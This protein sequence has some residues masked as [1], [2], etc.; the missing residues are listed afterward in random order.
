M[1]LVIKKKQNLK[2]DVVIKYRVVCQRLCTVMLGFCERQILFTLDKSHALQVNLS[3][4]FQI[5]RER[6]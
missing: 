4:V 2:M 3:E 1:R 6:L 5:A